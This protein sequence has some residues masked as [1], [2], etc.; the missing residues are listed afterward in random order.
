MGQAHSRLGVHVTAT[1]STGGANNKFKSASV[2]FVNCAGDGSIGI[3]PT[4][5]KKSIIITDIIHGGTGD[6]AKISYRDGPSASSPKTI[7]IVGASSSHNFFMPLR[8]P[9][10]KFVSLDEGAKVTIQYYEE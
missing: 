9:P 4:D 1:Q 6:S 8:V 7:I 5:S 3:N 2:F 10:G